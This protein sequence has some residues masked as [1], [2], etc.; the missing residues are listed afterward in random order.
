MQRRFVTTLS[1]LAVFVSGLH[2]ASVHPV[3]AQDA[4]ILITGGRVMDG[5]GNPWMRADVLIRGDRIEAMGDLSGV[6]AD[7]VA[8]SFRDCPEVVYAMRVAARVD[9]RAEVGGEAPDELRDFLGGPNVQAP[10]ETDLPSALVSVQCRLT[11]ASAP[12]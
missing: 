2:G 8:Q 12:E 6:S 3:A 4:S 1:V 11:E 5:T 9:R 7:E 10:S